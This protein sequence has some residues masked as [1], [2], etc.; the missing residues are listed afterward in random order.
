MNNIKE[1]FIQK[2]AAPEGLY[3]RVNV[4]FQSCYYAA[5]QYQNNL[6]DNVSHNVCSIINLIILLRLLMRTE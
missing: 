3:I 2:H 1:V 5:L 4:T 6:S